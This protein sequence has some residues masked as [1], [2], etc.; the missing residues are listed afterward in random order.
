LLENVLISVILQ[1][2]RRAALGSNILHRLLLF[3]GCTG[4]Q[5]YS[6]KDALSISNYN[7]AH[8]LL[9]P[10]LQALQDLPLVL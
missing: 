5:V 4:M 8:I 10:R 3:A 2:V 1:L 6:P 7:H 9:L